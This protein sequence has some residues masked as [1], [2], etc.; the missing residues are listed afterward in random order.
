MAAEVAK[1]ALS[2][3][4]GPPA[5]LARLG[6]DVVAAMPSGANYIEANGKSCT[7]EVLWP[8]GVEGSTLPPQQRQGSPAREYPFQIDPFQQTAINAL[9]AGHNVL[10]AAHTS[11][12]KTVVAE[13]AFAMGLR[14][15][16]LQPV[17]AA[18]VEGCSG[19]ALF[20]LYWHDG[21]RVV[22][23]SPLKALSNQ[24]YRELAQE[25]GDVGLM[26]GDV[27]INPH[28]TCLVMTTEI[29][30]SMLYRGA[31]VVREV[32][33]LVYD[34]VHYLRDAERGVVWEESIVLAPKACRM[35]FLSATIP[36]SAEFA[37]WVAATH[38]SPVH[39]VYTEYRPTPLQHY[40][41][42]AGLARLS[43]CRPSSVLF[44]CLQ[45]N[46]YTHA[47]V[48]CLP[49][50]SRTAQQQQPPRAGEEARQSQAKT[51]PGSD[52]FRLV[53]M[54][55]SRG[56]DPFIVFS[57]SKREC[58]GLALSLA[59]L[60]LNSGD[61]GRSWRG[62]SAWPPGR[63]ACKLLRSP[64]LNAIDVL[65]E[66][67]QRLPQ[68]GALLPMLKRGIGVHHSGLLPIL[69]EV[70][71]LLFQVRPAD[72]AQGRSRPAAAGCCCACL[73]AWGGGP[74]QG[75]VCHRDLLHR[76][77]HARQTVAFTRARKWDGGAYR[78]LRSGEY[79]Q[80]SGRAGRR[81]L[82]DRGIVILMLDARMEPS[83]AR[84]MVKG[85]ADPLVS[86]FQLRY[87]QLL[88]LARTEG[89]T[90]E[91]LLQASFRQWQL[92]HALPQLE[93]RV[94]ELSAARDAVAV[95]QEEQVT[96]FAELLQSR[97]RLA[98]ALREAVADPA[99][100]LRFLQ[101]GRLHQH[102]PGAGAAGSHGKAAAGRQQQGAGEPAAAGGVSGAGPEVLRRLSGRE[103]GRL[104]SR[105][106][107]VEARLAA[108][109]LWGDAGLL[110][111]WRRCR[112]GGAAGAARAARREL[113]AAQGLVLADE[114]AARHRVLR[115]LGYL[116]AARAEQQSV[117]LA[118]RAGMP[119]PHW[120]N[121]LPARCRSCAAAA[122][123]VASGGLVTAKG[124]LAA[125]L[126]SGHDELVL[127]ELLLGGAFAE[128]SP[129]Q[130]APEALAGP[131]AALRKAARRVGTA[132]ADAKLGVNVDE[133]VE[134]FRPELMEA[135][136]AWARGQ[137]F[138]D[139][140]ALAP[141]VFE[142]S[143]VRAVRRLEELMR[144]VSGAL[145]GIGD[146]D[147]AGRFDD[148]CARIKRDIIFA[149]S[150]YL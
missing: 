146:N 112:S 80:M 42:P 90:A 111:A 130:L 88:Q 86:A 50:A 141:D 48:T 107:A 15:Q 79:I 143:L 109:A 89:T 74:A 83:T 69:K 120:P 44:R 100:A 97:L 134:K 115:R 38:G 49:R 103:V 128:L 57:F 148:A 117:R 124:R 22:Y 147:L 6:D 8:P 139:V 30:R 142:G 82:D 99:A 65:S 138:A 133:F 27:T 12:G 105:L 123:A 47:A 87:S 136:G 51:G 60:D 19:F 84:D 46:L 61:E 1:R 67:D 77:Q 16:L 18:Y 98:E 3:E 108:H 59:G 37:G 31:E 64:G 113:K 68:I 145:R 71:E 39:V 91:M 95:P 132:A 23:T 52:I 25:F 45:P 92:R 33:L 144:Q 54:V 29:L 125:D 40:L 81:G 76:A 78:W 56:Y 43:H 58:E 149:A 17:A 24:K 13:Y 26:T 122:A 135:C 126:A 5:K 140:L 32:G 94:A 137:R 104:V 34:E 127:A 14:W 20:T 114:L 4:N 73:A 110:P 118:L 35:A 36:N 102:Q 116:D 2:A 63:S 129:D 9:E 106:E 66:E 62:C 85:A 119:C 70:V 21:M 53:L 41:F 101:P 93:Q 72:R 55:M 131:L 121:C 11:A 28:A 75:A 150:L 10:V 7:H 96:S